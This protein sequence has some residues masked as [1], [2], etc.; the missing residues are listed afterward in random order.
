[1]AKKEVFYICETCGQ[2]FQLESE[3][4][5]CEKYHYK[6]VGLKDATYSL[7]DNKKEYPTTINVLLKN[8]AGTERVI[9]YTRKG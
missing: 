6:L 4:N 9:T 7:S 5:R 2:R 1:M 8:G 3:A